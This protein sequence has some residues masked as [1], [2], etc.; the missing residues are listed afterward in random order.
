M[1]EEYWLLLSLVAISATISNA[2]DLFLGEI[3][4]VLVSC[5]YQSSLYL[6]DKLNQTY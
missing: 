3:S 5:V 2:T 4:F 6:S 1:V